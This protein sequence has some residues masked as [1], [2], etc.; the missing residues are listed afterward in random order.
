MKL[1]IA[2]PSKNRPFSGTFNY[3]K[4]VKNFPVYVYVHEPEYDL[5][6]E[7]MPGHFTI[8]PHDKESI[9]QIRGFIIKTHFEKN[10]AVLM[11]DDDL[12]GIY[13][14]EGEYLCSLNSILKEIEKRMENADILCFYVC[15]DFCNGSFYKKKPAPVE[16]GMINNAYVICPTAYQKGLRMCD[17]KECS[18]DY[19][20]SVSAINM[21]LKISRIPFICFFDVCG[22]ETHFGR[23]WYAIS[24]I[25]LYEK[26]GSIFPLYL[27]K[28]NYI[29]TLFYF[30]QLIKKP[31]EA[32]VYSPL[33]NAVIDYLI[34]Y[35]NNPGLPEPYARLKNQLIETKK[36][37]SGKPLTDNFIYDPIGLTQFEQFPELREKYP[38]AAAAYQANKLEDGFVFPKY[39]FEDWNK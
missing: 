37:I 26:Y 9:G 34:D 3:L 18:E 19:E 39:R 4:T 22:P 33:S 7:F 29:T 8:I 24:G 25:K 14:L 38:N 28:E 12:K 30:P 1:A 13:S 31:G 36:A 16:H 32:P 6:K 23:I 10:E 2:V 17:E 21:G 11:M 20:M 15:S 35:H 27:N 5:Y